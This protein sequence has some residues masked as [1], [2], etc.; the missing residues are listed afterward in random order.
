MSYKEFEDEAGQRV[1]TR[2]SKGRFTKKSSIKPLPAELRAKK[3]KWST[4]EEPVLDDLYEKFKKLQPMLNPKKDCRDVFE[5][6]HRYLIASGGMISKVIDRTT[7]KPYGFLVR[8]PSST[9]P[10]VIF[11]R[12]IKYNNDCTNT[13]FQK[14][15][16]IISTMICGE[17]WK[18]KREERG[19]WIDDVPFEV[20]YH[21]TNGFIVV[22]D[23]GI[24]SVLAP[25]KFYYVRG[26]LMNEVEREGYVVNENII[27]YIEGFEQKA[28]NYYKN[29]E[30]SKTF[31]ALPFI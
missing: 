21:E 30:K 24:T 27:N 26:R 8:I 3:S 15:N 29:N 25:D 31:V 19:E 22:G 4:E 28:R 9:N 13:Y 20:F 5:A 23:E 10:D 2:D 12:F 6:V 17:R 18:E 14:A 16:A 7:N 11:M 1:L